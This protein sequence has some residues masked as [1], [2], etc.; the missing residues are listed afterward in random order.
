MRN[1]ASCNVGNCS[2]IRRESVL[3]ILESRCF[4]SVTVASTTSNS[5]SDISGTVVA[6]IQ[7]GDNSEVGGAPGVAIANNGT[8]TTSAD[9]GWCSDESEGFDSG[10]QQVQ[11]A[12]NAGASGGSS[13]L[14]VQEAPTLNSSTGSNGTFS[15]VTITAAVDGWGMAM[16]WEGVV[17]NFYDGNTLLQSEQVGPLGVDTTNANTNDPEQ[18]TTT[19]STTFSNCTSITVDAEVQM[20]TVAGEYP[21]PNDIAGAIAV[22]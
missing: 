5:I 10:W 3:E 20:Y 12:V 4:K 2:T 18:S 9:V 16:Q 13:S 19:I 11:F 22:S 15:Q 17:V 6:Q 7:V 1:S 21:G 8:E 14:A